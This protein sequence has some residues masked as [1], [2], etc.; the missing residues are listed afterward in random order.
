MIRKPIGKLIDK[1]GSKLF[2]L[3]ALIHVCDNWPDLLK[4][5]FFGGQTY[6]T[7]RDY[8]GNELSLRF[9]EKNMN[10]VIQLA[11]VLFRCWGKYE[12]SGD[13]ISIHFT[14][15]KESF[16]LPEVLSNETHFR[17]LSMFSLLSRLNANVKP[18]DEGH[19]M[20]FIDGLTW[21]V[22]KK[23][24]SD[25]E[26]GPLLPYLHEPYEY[27]A[28]FT[29]ALK[30]GG[31]FIDV[32]AYVGGYAIRACKIRSC[33]VV[34]LEPD[35]ENFSLLMMNIELNRCSR[36]H[37]LNVAAG[38]NEEL[39]PLY[40]PEPRM[41]TLSYSLVRKGVLRGY[42]KVMPLDEVVLSI[43]GD[44]GVQLMKIDVEGAELEVLKG[45]MGTLNRT[46]YLMIEVWP[47]TENQVLDLLKKCKFNLVDVCKY[48]AFFK[49]T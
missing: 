23:V 8:R 6:T 30:G 40:A 26:G 42:V 19:Y 9:D 47:H 22:R 5:Y 48:N 10:K 31:I 24:L 49:R 17:N 14:H 36:I 25:T 11:G 4:V 7:L 33:L 32:G 21:V 41:P 28:W 2:S 18:L 16:R 20:S 45:A 13:T 29:R 43:V 12:L 39:K 27:R 35:G 1:L 34:A 37:A 15:S 3:R 44:C 38:A 46:H